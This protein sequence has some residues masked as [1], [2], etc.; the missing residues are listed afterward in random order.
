MRKDTTHLHNVKVIKER[1]PRMEMA[2]VYIDKTRYDIDPEDI[3][4]AVIC[5]VRHII[6]GNYRKSVLVK[7]VWFNDTDKQYG[8]EVLIITDENISNKIEEYE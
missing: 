4:D 7:N 3:V 2:T 8:A 5:A 1:S 6:S